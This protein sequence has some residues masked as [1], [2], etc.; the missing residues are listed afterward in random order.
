MAYFAK[1]EDGIVTNVIIADQEFIDAGYV[2]GTWLETTFSA[3][4]GVVYEQPINGNITELIPTDTPCV[5]KNYADI[6]YTYDAVRDA[7]I[8]PKPDGNWVLNE[9]TCLWEK[10]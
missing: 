6:G 3:V 10:V 8:A 4:G 9:N 2:E 5:R 1:I 7:F